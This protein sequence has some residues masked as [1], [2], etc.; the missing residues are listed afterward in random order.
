M[1][2]IY[3]PSA[4][5]GVPPMTDTPP[6][7]RP[8]ADECILAVN[9][10]GYDETD[11]TP[12]RDAM[13]V[14]RVGGDCAICFGSIVPGERVRAKVERLNEGKPV[15]KTFRFCALC[16]AAMVSERDGEALMERYEI[17]RSNAAAKESPRG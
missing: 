17:G 8:S 1:A 11:I 2:D 13:V 4:G 14:A 10:W 16:C 12:L 7:V 3:R 6:P 5:E 9:P 15:V